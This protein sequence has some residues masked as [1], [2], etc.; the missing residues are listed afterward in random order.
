MSY[1]LGPAGGRG[2]CIGRLRQ[3]DLGRR[4]DSEVDALGVYI[5]ST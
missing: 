3:G 1:E 5:A 4:A 2:T